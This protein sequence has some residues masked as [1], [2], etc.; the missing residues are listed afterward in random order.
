MNQSFNNV[1]RKVPFQ[2]YT[3][4]PS[5]GQYPQMNNPSMLQALHAQQQQLQQRQSQQAS[6]S[7]S[8]TVA[9]QNQSALQQA[10]YVD[11]VQRAKQQHQEQANKLFSQLSMQQIQSLFCKPGLLP[12]QLQM[13]QQQQVVVT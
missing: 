5:G 7:A 3:M 11:A 13:L 12:Q 6:S 10:A 4:F 8:T 9:A 1:S 2:Y